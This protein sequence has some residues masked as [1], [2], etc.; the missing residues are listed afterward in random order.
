MTTGPI[1]P[2][3]KIKGIIRRRWPRQV[4][5]GLIVP[6][7][8]IT[9][10]LAYF[11]RSLIYLPTRGAVEVAEAGFAEDQL[12]PVNRQAD[13]GVT[14]HGW[15]ILAD[16][17][18]SETVALPPDDNRPLILYFPGNGGHRGYRAKEIHQ[19]TELGCHVLYFD[20][21]GYAENAGKPTED[22]LARDAQGVWSFAVDEL[23][24]PPARIV[25]WGESLGG[26]VATRLTSDLCAAE[27]PP[28]GLILRGTFTSL[29]DAASYHYPWLPVRWVLVDRFPSI[30]RIG[31]V[32]CP[33]LVIHGR[34]DTIVPFEL[35]KRLFDAAPANSMTGMAKTFIELPQAGHNDIMYV[36]ADEVREAVQHFLTRL[37]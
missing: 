34:Q 1:E 18:A 36:A 17:T 28:R 16:G 25:I 37:K 13:D 8:F 20:Y 33:L 35:G 22:D 4:A 5:L 19:F 31:T 32:T 30:D 6:Y 23:N 3:G 27:T 2:A 29:V 21:R 7:G 10:M 11:Q 15:L 14:L 9:A 26:G 12:L 24:V